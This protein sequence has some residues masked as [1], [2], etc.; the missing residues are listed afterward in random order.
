M[1]GDFYH[2]HCSFAQHIYLIIY[3]LY[4][5][6][7]YSDVYVVYIFFRQNIFMFNIKEILFD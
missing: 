7:A 2:F 5:K 4:R 3:L 1:L 6:K